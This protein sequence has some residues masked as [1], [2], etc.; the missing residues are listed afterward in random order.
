MINEPV[1]VM[2]FCVKPYTIKELS[3]MYNMCS[4]TFRRNIAGIQYQLGKRKGHFYSIKQ[5]ETIIA[6]MGRP[7]E[8]V[9][10]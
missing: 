9:E 6:H 1:T 3:V 10:T 2:R 8:V 5:I 7:Y 4:R